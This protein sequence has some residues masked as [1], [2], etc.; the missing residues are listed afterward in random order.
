MS[1]SKNAKLILSAILLTAAL[2]LSVLYYKAKKHGEIILAKASEY[3]SKKSGR[4][5][6]IGSLS[7]SIIDGL[8]MKDVSIKEKDA[9]TDFFS[10]KRAEIKIDEKKFINGELVFKKAAFY[11][12][13][14]RIENREGQWN[15]KDLI[16]L[17]PPSQKP[18][19]L[20]WNAKEFSFEDFFI[21]FFL[22]DMEVSLDKSDLHISHRSLTAGNFFFSLSSK[23]SLIKEKDFFSASIETEGDLVYDYALLKSARIDAN[24]EDISY[25][26][27]SIKSLSFSGNFLDLDKKSFSNFN[28]DLKV[29][30]LFIPSLKK[31]FSSFSNNLE[32]I[33]KALGKNILKEED[34]SMK[35]LSISARSKNSESE[36]NLSMD[37]NLLDIQFSSLASLDRGDNINAVLE[38]SDSKIKLSALS[39]F[40]KVKF[41]DDFSETLSKSLEE[42]IL[43]F[44]KTIILKIVK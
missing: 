41:K 27:I 19:Q 6:I 26:Q 16:K 37:S 28:S 10:F 21:S 42:M 14:L 2:S 31:N 15:F 9:K 32:A 1:M 4:K 33:E 20:V 11:G 34:F 29:E 39:D 23:L 17:L 36:I 12:G 30:N 25:K 24:M 7:Y 43:K 5:V 38:I 44:E 8:I 35:E 22:D 18:I 40:N 3:L 13:K